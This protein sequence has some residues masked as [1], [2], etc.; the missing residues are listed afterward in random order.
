MASISSQN[1]DDNCF[2]FIAVHINYLSF[3]VRLNGFPRKV[4]ELNP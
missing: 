4:K 1:V 3:P 2:A